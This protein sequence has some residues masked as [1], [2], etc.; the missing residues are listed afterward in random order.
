MKHLFNRTAIIFVLCAMASL[1]AL[2]T[3]T[4]RKVTFSRPLMV[5]GTPVKAGTYKV[6]FDDQTGAFM[7]LD[8]KKVIV[9]ATARLEKV[10]GRYNGAYAV[11]T[12]GENSVLVSINMNSDSQA[13][14]VNDNENMKPMTP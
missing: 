2:A 4:T 9:K 10:Q 11:Q 6:T 3:S 12:N 5:N 1:T 14:I 8:G 13:V 7:L